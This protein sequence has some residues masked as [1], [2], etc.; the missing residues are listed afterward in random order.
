ML[1]ESK[2]DERGRVLRIAAPVV[3]TWEEDPEYLQTRE[4]SVISSRTLHLP[5]SAAMTRDA[6]F[7]LGAC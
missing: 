5:Q 1:M 4:R 2:G 6:V 3:R 7:F